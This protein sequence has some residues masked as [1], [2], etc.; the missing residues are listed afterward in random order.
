MISCFISSKKSAETFAL[1]CINT[2]CS[3]SL[4]ASLEFEAT[5]V[6]F[7]FNF[8]KNSLCFQTLFLLT[9]KLFYCFLNS[10]FNFAKKPFSLPGIVTSIFSPNTLLAISIYAFPDGA[11]LF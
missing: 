5:L 2:R 8:L 4:A 1:S 9:S 10:L 6:S 11:L 3:L 7:L